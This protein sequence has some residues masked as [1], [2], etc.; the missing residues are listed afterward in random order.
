MT[1]VRSAATADPETGDGVPPDLAAAFAG[2]H[3]LGVAFSG[4]VDSSVLLAA[5]G[6]DPGRRPGGGRARASRPA[7]PPTSARRPTTSPGSSAYRWS[8]SR[9]T[10]ATA[11]ST[12]PTAPTAASTARTSCSPGSATTWPRRTGSTRSR[13]ARTPTTPGGPTGPGARAATNHRVLR[14]L[15]DAGLDKAAVRRL[16]RAWALP[17]A[18]KPAAPCL[19]SRIPHHSEV[20]PEKL[21]QIEPAEAALRGARVR[22]PPGP[23]PRRHRPDRAD[24]GRSGPGGG[25][26][27]ARARC[28]RPWSG[29]A[30]ATP[31]STWPGCSPATSP[32]PCCGETAAHG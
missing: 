31:P 18:D 11:R 16:A 23:P 21:A 9:P 6:A 10:R 20:T 26:A 5:R 15:A 3:R 2:V 32:S 25:R 24:R 12:G 8:R 14:P 19:A 17:S 4:G 28:G 30:S 22:R 7:W 27:A 29:P 1:P 13:T